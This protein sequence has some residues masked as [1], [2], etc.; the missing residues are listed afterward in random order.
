MEDVVAVKFR[1]AKRGDACVMT[2][3]RVFGPVD[4]APLLDALARVLPLVGFESPSDLRLC[5][6]LSE[7]RNFEYFYEALIEFAASKGGGK[8]Y[9]DEWL[10][11]H[12]TDDG[13]RKDIYS[14]G[15]PLS[16][17]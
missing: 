15:K 9:E 6:N 7:A 11:A 3:G 17:G 5:D 8:V 12:R 10:A 4:S 2:W 1:D 14:L 13:L 16:A